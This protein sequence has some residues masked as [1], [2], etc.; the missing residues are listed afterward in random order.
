MK[1]WSSKSDKSHVLLR[2]HL[3]FFLIL[4]SFTVFAGNDNNIVPGAERTELYFPLLKY[5]KIAVVAN[6]ASLVGRV[7]LVDTLVNCGIRVTRIFCPEHGFR[8]FDEAGKEIRGGVDTLT[9]I[10]VVSLYGKKKKPDPDDMEKIDL[11]L[12]D[13]QDVGVRFFTY[14]STL[15]YVMEACAENHIPLLILDRPNPNGFYVDGPV[16]DS[17]CR[18]F[19]GMHPV[20]IVY[21]MTIG[22]YARMVNGEGWLKNGV[23]C[24]LDVISI[25]NYSHASLYEL[26]VRPSPN[27]PDIN[28]IY[29]YPSL[30]LFEGTP[31]SVGRGTEFPFEVF[32]HPEMKGFSFSFIPR[33]LKG[34]STNPPCGNERCLGIDLRDF[35]KT[36]P[37]MFGRINLSWVTMAFRDLGS[38]PSFFTPFFDLLAGNHQLKEQ[39]K[40]GLPESEIRKSWQP[41]I[42]KFMKIRQKY[43]LYP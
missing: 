29:L 3:L 28:A 22:E 40:K 43:L 30:G 36:H 11:V 37:R 16:L 21:G 8:K 34:F 14:I 20:P 15:T 32:G 2:G 35:Y 6:P 38:Q 33:I 31:V 7:N 13:L 9:G 17:T 26:P 12:F 10:Q 39:I 1:I 4:W 18:S 24:K 27:L 5:K 25:D 41:E 23:A 19:I 42:D